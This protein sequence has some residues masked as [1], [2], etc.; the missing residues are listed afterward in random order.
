MF[1]A[2][3][4][5]SALKKIIKP[6]FFGKIQNKVKIWTSIFFSFR[7]FC[8][9]IMIKRNQVKT[10]RFNGEVTLKCKSYKTMIL[11][12]TC[13]CVGGRNTCILENHVVSGWDWLELQPSYNRRDEG[14]AGER[15]GSLTPVK[16]TVKSIL[17]SPDQLLT[18]STTLCCNEQSR[19]CVF[20]LWSCIS[21]FHVVWSVL[22]VV[23]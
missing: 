13:N 1:T 3:G 16:R 9:F 10:N 14:L 4:D 22:M 17:R 21:L 7:D 2:I 19:T 15:Y 20:V 23:W 18:R 8:L 5:F 12:V 11:K 6:N